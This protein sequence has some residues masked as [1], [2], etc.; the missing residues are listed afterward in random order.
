MPHGI[1]NGGMKARDNPFRS[2]LVESVSFLNADEDDET[3]LSRL[4]DMNWRGLILGNHGSGKTTLLENL[5]D[6]LR[7]DGRSV[8]LLN[9]DGHRRVN[10]ETFNTFFDTLKPEDTI[11]LDGIDY[12][13][14][15]A[16]WKL[17]GFACMGLVATGHRTGRLPVWVHRSTSVRLLSQIVSRIA[18]AQADELSDVL[19]GLFAKHQG[20]IRLCLMALYDRYAKKGIPC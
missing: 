15:R 11:L 2:E 14:A 3:R 6:R 17:R 20:D 7:Q 9:T 18:P 19:P 8:Q 10:M 16:W 12:L 5:H 1:D 13:P 4:A